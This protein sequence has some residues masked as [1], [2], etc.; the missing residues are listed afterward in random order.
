[1]WVT[2][3][4]TCALPI[5]NSPQRERQDTDPPPGCASLNTAS[6]LH[7]D[8]SLGIGIVVPGAALAGEDEPEKEDEVEEKEEEET[9]SGRRGSRGADIAARS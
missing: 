1:M 6:A 7:G 2:G 8:A 3:V 5:W 4:Q 9:D